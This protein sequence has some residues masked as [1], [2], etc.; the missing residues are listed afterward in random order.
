MCEMKMLL[1]P[2]VWLNRL[3][4]MP[5]GRDMVIVAGMPKSGT[6]A[7]AR[8]LASATGGNVCSDPFYQLDQKKIAFREDIFNNKVTLESLWKRHRDIFFSGSIIKDPNFP[9][10]ISEIKEFLPEVK[11]VS[12]VRDP[13]DNIRSVLDRLKLPGNPSSID[14]D[15][16]DIPP[17]WRNVLKGNNPDIP[18]ENY[19]EVLAWRWR[20]SAEAFLQY[21]DICVEIRY[22]DFNKMKSESIAGLA[23]K[24]GYE[25]LRNIDHLVNVQYQPRGNPDVRWDSFFGETVLGSIE[26]ITCPA[27]RE[28]GYDP[29]TIR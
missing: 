4:P 5:E 3:R 12:I 13:R 15:V 16:V 1:R 2:R 18:G 29:V 27:M 10:F 14:L 8:L 26:E 22:E 17:T 21:R 7:I 23:R 28:F 20:L 24:L 19:A 25:K 6:T 9:F 11:L